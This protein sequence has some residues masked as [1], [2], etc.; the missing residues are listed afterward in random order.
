MLARRRGRATILAIGFI[1]ALATGLPRIEFE[2]HAERFLSETHPARVRYQDFKSKFGLDTPILVLLETEDVFREDFLHSL[3]ALHER[4]EAEVPWVAEVESLATA[5]WLEAEDGWLRA[6]TIRDRLADAPRETE[7]S[8]ADLAR[9]IDQ[10]PAYA[11]FLVS[12]D[13]RLTT[14]TLRLE[15]FPGQDARG[16]DSDSGLS[17][18]QARESVRQVRALT[19]A[20]APPG[21]QIQLAGNPVV[22]ESLAR[23]IQTDM[24][25]FAGWAMLV[26]G[27]SLFFL[28]KRLSAALLPVAVSLAAIVG[29]LGAAGWAGQP[30]NVASQ[31]LP[32]LLLAVGISA[33]THLLAAFYRAWDESGDRASAIA[34]SLEHAGPATLLTGLTT[35]AGLASFAAASDLA[36]VHQLGLLAPVG[37]LLTLALTLLGLPLLLGALPIQ[38]REAKA[39]GPAALTQ[40]FGATLSDV[41]V[42]ALH[43]KRPVLLAAALVAGIALASSLRIEADND[44]LAYFPE[45]HPIR[46]STQHFDD[47]LA[48]SINL[49]LLVE[50]GRAGGLHE[51]AVVAAFD[52]FGEAALRT[53]AEG[54]AR[55]QKTLSYVDLL[56]ET[57]AALTEDEMAPSP[58]PG[59]RPLIAQELL[60]FEATGA[61]GLPRFVTD[62]DGTARITLRGPWVASKEYARL[63]P[64]LEAAL[65]TALPAGLRVE[66]TGLIMLFAEAV[67]ATSRAFAESYGTAVLLITLLMIGFVGHLRG[68]L[69]SMLPNLLPILLALGLMGQLGIDLDLFTLLIGSIALGLAVDDTLHLVHAFRRF[70]RETGDLEAAIRRGLETTGAAICTSS[71][72]LGLGFSGFLFSSMANLVH[73][74]AITVLSIVLAFAIDVV[75]LP[76]LCGWILG[77]APTREAPRLPDP[78]PVS[79]RSP[80][81]EALPWSGEP[82]QRVLRETQGASLD[83][84]ATP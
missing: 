48:G 23:A 59:D 15:A 21:V 16:Q 80:T 41:G 66:S 33:S 27:A 68:G 6:G 77:P 12:D 42:A 32:P 63:V 5:R 73:F 17:A 49:E 20:W 70:Y 39:A 28:F 14:L 26:M 37:V 50:T 79:L 61:E 84:R 51:P 25:R 55:I 82:V 22:N 57:H 62:Q 30:L 43:H 9:H 56:R 60:L 18:L 69:L 8:R 81:G 58:L 72:A 31:I 4:L 10:N 47:A 78:V 53:P 44:A 36:P 13:H 54:E 74:G 40:R 45:H 34:Q 7:T 2:T 67:Q 29:T 71:V 46:T 64:R 35:A 3:S 38:R 24:R 65:E 83:E 52:A 76:A 75:L 1:A 11:R 19:E